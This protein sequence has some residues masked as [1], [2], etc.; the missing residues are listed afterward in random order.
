MEA[1]ELR[2]QAGKV[3][4]LWFPGNFP[5]PPFVA[6]EKMNSAPGTRL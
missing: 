4:M 2:F 6:W 5:S 1:A 3:P